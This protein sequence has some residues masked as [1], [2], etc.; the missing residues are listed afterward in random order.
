MKPIALSLALLLTAFVIGTTIAS[1]Q[2]TREVKKTIPL[3]ADGKL[4]IDTYKGSITI[5]SWDKAEVDMVATIEPDGFDRDDV[6]KVQYTEIRV[7]GSGDF[8][9]ITSDYDRVNSHFHGFLGLFGDGSG[10]LPS[11]HYAIKMPSTAKLR[12]KDY[13]SDT[14]ISGLAGP[15]EINTYKGSVVMNNVRGPV[16]LETYRG[17]AKI[18]YAEYTGSNRMKTYKGKIDLRLPGDASFDLDAD[19]GRRVDF[20][21]DFEHI[22]RT[23]HHGSVRYKGAANGGSN[24]LTLESEKGEFTIMKKQAD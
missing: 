22:E 20:E 3:Q 18:S 6:E 13:R 9:R 1:A 5:E 2:H 19:F 4:T 10:S 16:D 24:T 15:L 14:K 11:V 8:V 17:N 12:I 7:D 21:T 23:G